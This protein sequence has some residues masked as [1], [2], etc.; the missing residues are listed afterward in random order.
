MVKKVMSFSGIHLTTEF[1][2]QSQTMQSSIKLMYT[3]KTQQH[4]DHVRR[5]PPALF[6]ELKQYSIKYVISHQKYFTEKLFTVEC[7]AGLTD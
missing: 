1:L 2:Q 6:L 4:C 3:K 7:G 5:K